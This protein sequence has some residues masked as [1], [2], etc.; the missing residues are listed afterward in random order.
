MRA[1]KQMFLGV[2]KEIS[3]LMGEQLYLVPCSYWMYL[4]PVNNTVECQYNNYLCLDN[5]FSNANFDKLMAFEKGV[6]ATM[7]R[8]KIDNW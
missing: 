4:T 1:A 6:E 7:R 3:N 2:V 5:S 8:M